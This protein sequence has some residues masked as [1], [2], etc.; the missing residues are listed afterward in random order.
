[1]GLNDLDRQA[2]VMNSTINPKVDIG[3][4][5]PLAIAS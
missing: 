5:H 2:V 4:K 1:M 3:I